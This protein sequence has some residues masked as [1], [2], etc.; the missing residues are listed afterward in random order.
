MC[1]GKHDI[2]RCEIED[3]F[4]ECVCGVIRAQVIVRTA[5]RSVNYLLTGGRL[6]ELNLRDQARRF[7][8]SG[9]Y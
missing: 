3:D 1:P 4:K 2:I 6:S 8:D 7:R 5:T 9:Q